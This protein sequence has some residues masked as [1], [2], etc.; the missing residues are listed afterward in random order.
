[1]RRLRSI[2]S[3]L[4]C[5]FACASVF[6]PRLLAQKNKPAPLTEA[7]IEEIREAGIDPNGRVGLYT[8]YVSE[9]ADT[10]K[11]LT[12]RSKTP[13]R[14]K[15]LDEELQDLTALMDEFGTNL[16]VFSDRHADIRKALKPLTEATDR[17]L[18]ILRALPGEPGFDLARKEAIESGE[19]LTDQAKRLLAEQTEYFKLHKDEQGQDRAEPK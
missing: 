17:W 13:T 11:S 7:Q 9:H 10:I 1:M 3:L 14:S 18:G 6:T 15:R 19:D 4:F 2:A 12:N 8:K 16:D 5:L